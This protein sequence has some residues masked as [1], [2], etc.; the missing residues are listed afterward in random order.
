MKQVTILFLSLFTSTMVS[1]E[2]VV[3][4]DSGRT[5][6]MVHP[7]SNKQLQAT[8]G[9]NH[10]VNFP[11]VPMVTPSMSPGKVFTRSIDHPYLSNPIFIVGYDMI[12]LSWLQEHKEKLKQNHAIGIV[13]NVKTEQQVNQLQQAAGGI[14]ITP[15]PGTKV[16]KQLSLVHYPV[17]ISSTLIE[18]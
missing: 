14:E 15:V 5:Q 13:V 8:P 3:I 17:L 11:R 7:P 4:Y 18:Q 2:P 6:P 9:K 16:A 10:Q 1:A 12:S